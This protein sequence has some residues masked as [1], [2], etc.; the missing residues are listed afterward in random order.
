M[1]EC[2]TGKALYDIRTNES[3]IQK[4]MYKL[5]S[6]TKLLENKNVANK[7]EAKIKL[8]ENL[9]KFEDLAERLKSIINGYTQTYKTVA[10]EAEGEFSDWK[11]FNYDEY[12]AYAGEVDL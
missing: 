3:E 2:D 6:V 7:T 11:S 8:K 1:L 12:D 9:G 10:G 4:D 5:S